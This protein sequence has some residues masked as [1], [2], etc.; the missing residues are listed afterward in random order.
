MRFMIFIN[1][2]FSHNTLRFISACFSERLT[3]NERWPA[4]TTTMNR[5]VEVHRD[6]PASPDAKN[7]TSPWH[8]RIPCLVL[9]SSM[10]ATVHICVFVFFSMPICC[11]ELCLVILFAWS[12]KVK[13]CHTN[14]SVLLYSV[15][16]FGRERNS[17]HNWYFSPGH[18]VPITTKSRKH[19]NVTFRDTVK[20][21]LTFIQAS[22][23]WAKKPWSLFLSCK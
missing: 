4:P 17:K 22:S 13:I 18:D 5:K 3:E 10:R 21:K 11:R 19:I 23:C 8:Y 9:I 20:T 16:R 14:T 1:R 12:N 6:G 15:P 2:S 7:M